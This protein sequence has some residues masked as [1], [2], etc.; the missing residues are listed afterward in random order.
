METTVRTSTACEAGGGG[1]SGFQR[2]PGQLGRMGLSE[3]E[4]PAER[5]GSLGVL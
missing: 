5:R 1:G 4:V 3:A 2:A